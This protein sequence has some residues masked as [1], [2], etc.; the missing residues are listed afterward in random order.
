MAGFEV[1]TEV[2]S[3]VIVVHPGRAV[4]I[5]KL[6]RDAMIM[7]HVRGLSMKERAGKMG[8]L[9]RFITSEGYTRRFNEAT[10]LTDNVLELDVQE[11]KTHD[12]VWRKRGALATRLNRVLRELDTEIAAIIEAGVGNEV[13]AA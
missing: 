4:H 2:E 10:K 6:L 3:D 13:P 11:K 5:V 9:Y 7:T 12:N 1:I 8:Q